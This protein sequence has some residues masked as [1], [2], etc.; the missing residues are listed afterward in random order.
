MSIH[1][2][3]SFPND[4][5]LGCLG[6]SMVGIKPRDKTSQSTAKTCEFER[7]LWLESL[8]ETFQNQGTHSD[9]VSYAAASS[10]RSQTVNS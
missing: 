8:L 9:Q 10:G 2:V 4:K 7:A 5:A 3:S 6:H 1:Q